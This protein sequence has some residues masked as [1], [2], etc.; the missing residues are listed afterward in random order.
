MGKENRSGKGWRREG[1]YIQNM[2]EIIKELIKY[3]LNTYNY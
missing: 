3:V 1:Y 2:Y